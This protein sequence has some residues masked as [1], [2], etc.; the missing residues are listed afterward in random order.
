MVTVNRTETT[1]IPHC[2]ETFFFNSATHMW[3]KITHT[4]PSVMAHF[5]IQFTKLSIHSGRLASDITP[6]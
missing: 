3:I 6:L 1:T 2:I 4:Q 5:K